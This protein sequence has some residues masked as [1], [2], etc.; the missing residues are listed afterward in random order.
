MYVTRQYLLTTSFA[1]SPKKLN[2][3]LA[4]KLINSQLL[5]KNSTIS[6]LPL[7]PNPK[8][9]ITIYTTTTSGSLLS[10]ATNTNIIIKNFLQF[11]RLF[12]NSK[13]F[14]STPLLKINLIYSSPLKPSI[15]TPTHAIPLFLK[16]KPLQ[17]NLFL[18]V[19]LALLLFLL[20]WHPVV[21]E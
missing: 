8:S 19:N 21:V 14:F 13:L 1:I 3:R 6:F 12:A 15:Y 16:K 10:Q 4:I 9:H 2:P 11:S 20:A 7:N 17:K 5:Q 18:F